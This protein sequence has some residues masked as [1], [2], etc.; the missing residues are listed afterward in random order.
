MSNNSYQINLPHFNWK[1][2][3]DAFT[4]VVTAINANRPV[5]GTGIRIT[6]MGDMGSLIETG[7]GGGSG[8]GGT[9]GGG[10]QWCQIYIKDTTGGGCVDKVIWYWGTLPAVPPGPPKPT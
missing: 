10:A 7:P 5:E 1:A 9:E 4:D 6:G 2:L 3:Q 8:P